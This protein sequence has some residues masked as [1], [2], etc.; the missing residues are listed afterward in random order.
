[1]QRRIQVSLNDHWQLVAVV[2]GAIVF[3]A[4]A[5]VSSRRRPG[6]GQPS[7]PDAQAAEPE[8]QR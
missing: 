2:L 3:A 7:V 6:V 8:T 5:Y 4:L 1:V